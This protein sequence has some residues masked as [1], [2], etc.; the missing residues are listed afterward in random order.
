MHTQFLVLLSVLLF[1][2][3]VKADIQISY[4]AHLSLTQSSISN[5]VDKHGAPEVFAG[6]QERVSYVSCEVIQTIESY[7]IPFEDSHQSFWSCFDQNNKSFKT[8][9]YA[10]DA[11]SRLISR[12]GGGSFELARFTDYAIGNSSGMGRFIE[13]IFGIQLPTGQS[14]TASVIFWSDKATMNTPI[15]TFTEGKKLYII[16]MRVTY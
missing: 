15:L 1:T 10:K 2:F 7:P 16:E 6:E 3:T 12:N 5:I 13:N 11:G 14:Q 8:V 4:K 9:F